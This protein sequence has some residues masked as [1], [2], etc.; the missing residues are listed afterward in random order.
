VLKPSNPIQKA[1]L[2]MRTMLC[3]PAA[4]AGVMMLAAPSAA[5]SEVVAARQAAVGASQGAGAGELASRLNETVVQVPVTV[6][7]PDGRP[8]T[9][10]MVITHFRPHGSGPFPVV[11]LS[12]GRT[13]S[14]RHDPA[15]VRL[16]PLAAHFI[17]R[18]F[19]VIVPTRIGY[20]ALG[21]DVDPELAGPCT[22]SNYGPVVS[23]MATQIAEAARFAGTLPWAD[24]SRILLLG[25]S[26]GGFGTIGAAALDVRGVVGA[27][28]AV[29]VMGG[30]PVPRRG[31]GPGSPC[32]ADRIEE[33]AAGLGAK[34]R[35]PMLWLYSENDVLAGASLPRRWHAAFT[36]S[37]ARAEFVQFP[38]IGD[39]GHLLLSRAYSQWRPVVDRYLAGLG[40]KVPVAASSLPATGFARV[41]EIARV[42]YVSPKTQQEQYA[43]FLKSDVPR[44]FVVSRSGS[45]AWRRGPEAVRAALETC[46]KNSRTPCALYAVDDRVVWKEAY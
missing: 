30:T 31:A 35:V 45:W 41:D 36:R 40:F 6:R 38:P 9:G 19:A 32:R 18:G 17:R 13:Y 46:Q 29:G 28:N 37:G 8:H 34:V 1:R 23:A 7:L 21:Q 2:E 44:A 16:L 20:G 11:V 5:W 39:N 26:Y 33:V 43:R 3:I 25:I 14:S 10:G 4:L 24:T 12:H 22:S 15:R 42:P 27:I